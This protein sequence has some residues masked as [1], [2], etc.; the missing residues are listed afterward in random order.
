MS[1]SSQSG[2]IGL[3]H[4]FDDYDQQKKRRPHPVPAAESQRIE[5]PTAAPAQPS[6]ED[7][8][9]P[10]AEKPE[11]GA[12]ELLAVL[13][14]GIFSTAIATVVYFRLIKSAGPT[15]VSQINYLIPVWAVI[16]GIVFLD[17]TV[18]QSH[19]TCGQQ[20]GTLSAGGRRSG[21]RGGSRHTISAGFRRS[22]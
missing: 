8:Q 11:P 7:Q 22:Y 13:M 2:A 9:R 16:V 5:E 20:R 21:G 3:A 6:G 19:G 1:E 18:Q 14:L 12:A 10:G 15:F 17:E 4:H